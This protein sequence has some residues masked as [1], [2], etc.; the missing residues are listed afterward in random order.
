MSKKDGGSTNVSWSSEDSYPLDDLRDWLHDMAID[1]G[2]MEPGADGE[3]RVTA[4]YLVRLCAY[5][6]A[7]RAQATQG[8]W[9]RAPGVPPGIVTNLIPYGESFPDKRIR[10]DD[11]GNVLMYDMQV[12]QGRPRRPEMQLIAW[13]DMECIAETINALPVLLSF[14]EGELK[15]REDGEK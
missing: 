10:R 11:A 1:I 7:L 14:I 12:C 6:R 13:A 8:R 15:K 5:L 2:F 9:M 4:E 3:A